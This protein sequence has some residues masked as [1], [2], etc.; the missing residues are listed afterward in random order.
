[1]GGKGETVARLKKGTRKA[2][3]TSL[4]PLMNL[5]FL[6]AQ[7]QQKRERWQKLPRQIPRGR[8]R[9]YPVPIPVSRSINDTGCDQTFPSTHPFPP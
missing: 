9:S 2:C 6:S 1:M 5:L 3:Y 7:A 4:G 8:V